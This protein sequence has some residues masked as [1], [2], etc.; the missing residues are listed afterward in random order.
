MLLGALDR[1]R[2]GRNKAIGDSFL[3]PQEKL[4]GPRMQVDG[5]RDFGSDEHALIVL[6]HAAEA[7]VPRIEL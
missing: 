2:S 7:I 4:V 5:A 6:A 1:R 3:E